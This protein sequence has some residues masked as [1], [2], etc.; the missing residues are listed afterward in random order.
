MHSSAK[1]MEIDLFFVMEKVLDKQI[2]VSYILGVDQI[3][4]AL[5]NPISSTKFLE[6]SHKLKV[7]LSP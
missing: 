6:L 4:N 2:I 3:A 1:H 5:T 7:I